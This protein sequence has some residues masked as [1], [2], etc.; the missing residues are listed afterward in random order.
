ME[1]ISSARQEEKSVV[2][3]KEEIVKGYVR[4]VTNMKE[5]QCDIGPSSQ[6]L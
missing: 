6:P 5:Y 1:N 3:M 2:M 4:S